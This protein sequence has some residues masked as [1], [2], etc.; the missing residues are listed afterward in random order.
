MYSVTKYDK[1]NHWSQEMHAITSYIEF[2][3]FKGKDNVLV[4]SLS[5]LGCLGLHD[6]NDPEEPGQ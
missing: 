1:V 5:R 6:G 2:E 3:H 4:D